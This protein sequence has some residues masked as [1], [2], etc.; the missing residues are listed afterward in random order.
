VILRFNNEFFCKIGVGFIKIVELLLLFGVFGFLKIVSKDSN[1]L[2]FVGIFK[3]LPVFFDFLSKLI[4]FLSDFDRFLHL[5][6]LDVLIKKTYFFLTRIRDEL[7]ID[8]L[9][10][11]LNSGVL[12]IFVI[13]M[14]LL[15][16]NSLL[17][18]ILDQNSLLY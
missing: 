12:G 8:R 4:G 5:L 3:D 11:H 1:F 6:S 15:G 7:L 18:L 14:L 10:K 17:L 13:K 2:I 9:V 16:L